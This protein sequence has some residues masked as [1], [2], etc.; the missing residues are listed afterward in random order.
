MDNGF[1]R[2]DLVRIPRRNML[3]K[4]SKVAPDG[5]C[6]LNSCLH[7]ATMHVLL[8]AVCLP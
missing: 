4:Y 3:M 7:Q 1:L 2:F 5:T 6:V 8:M